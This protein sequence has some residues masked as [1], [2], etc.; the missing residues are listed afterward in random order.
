M[1]MK[2]VKHR[3]LLLKLEEIV[4]DGIVPL[5]IK[6][7]DE[8]YIGNC[9]LDDLYFSR[10]GDEP[11][12]ITMPNLTIKEIRHLMEIRPDQSKLNEKIFTPKDA[13][14]L[15]QNYRYFPGFSEIEAF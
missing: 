11:F 4:T 13:E 1:V 15:W 5:L 14:S 6:E 3:D 9:R 2:H 8:K 10:N 12:D 7:G